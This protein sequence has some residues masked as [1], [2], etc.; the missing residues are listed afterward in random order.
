[1]PSKLAILRVIV[2]GASATRYKEADAAEAITPGHLVDLNGS[3]G[4]VKNGAVIGTSGNLPLAVAVENDIFGKTIDDAYAIGDRV[5]Y[6]YLNSGDEFMGFV[7][8]GA[9]AIV[10]NDYL[11]TNAAGT[12]IKG[13]AANAVARARQAIDNSAGGA[14]ARFRAIVL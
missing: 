4:A 11:T 2:N 8:A 12:L 13:T 10:F 7:P 5:I 6:G 3:G 1:M 9:V 14:I